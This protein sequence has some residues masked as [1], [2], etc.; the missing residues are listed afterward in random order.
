MGIL[1][2]FPGAPSISSSVHRH[3]KDWLGCSFAGP[4]RSRDIDGGGTQSPYQPFGDEGSSVSFER[5]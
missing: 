2:P 5:H 4:N 3:V 1:S